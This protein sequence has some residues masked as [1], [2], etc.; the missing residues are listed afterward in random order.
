MIGHDQHRSHEELQQLLDGTLHQ[1]LAESIERHLSTCR[2]CQS[3]LEETAGNR[4]WWE[5]TATNLRSPRAG[6]S[7]VKS[8]SPVPIPELGPVSEDS[9]IHRLSQD[10]CLGP[11][12]LEDTV[13]FGGTGIVLQALDQQLQRRVAV[14]VLYPHLAAHGASRQRFAREAQAAAAVVHPSVVPIHA[15]NAEH[16]PPYLVMTFVP[17]GS[18]QQRL[19]RHGALELVEILRIA[20]QI[21]EGLAAAHA[22]GLI[23]RDVK[24]ANIL[25]EEGTDRVLLSDFG[26][27]RALDDATLTA[28][29]FVAGTPPYMSPEQ[30][31]GDAVDFRSD[32]FSVG[33][34]L[35]AMACGRPPFVGGSA[36]SILQQV[37][38]KPTPPVRTIN[39]RMPAW[40]DRLIKL[41]HAKLPQQR[42][43]SAQA[44]ADLLRQC[45]AHVQRP[46]TFPLPRELAA[47]H[48]AK[49]RSLAGFSGG[50]GVG[51]MLALVMWMIWPIRPSIHSARITPG[52][53]QPYSSGPAPSGF[54]TNSIQPTSS[55]PTVFADSSA[56][57]IDRRLNTL[58]CQLLDSIER[59]KEILK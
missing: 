34:L 5:S 22:Q 57:E 4:Q 25:L 1:T 30:A 43:G 19:D 8:K 17:G 38:D 46:T 47:P 32:I 12:R 7:H 36:L 6:T 48:R 23:H 54:T 9:W 41:C 10:G 14:K 35:F 31:R 26:L 13:G 40:L 29:G 50:I 56:D 45:L 44:L 55:F 16:D 51:L 52:A 15:V 39:E 37:N 59:T 21:A 27:A 11:Y 3:R 18:L 24:P 28:S 20:L 49:W 53:S 42:I 58:R 33:S 2:I